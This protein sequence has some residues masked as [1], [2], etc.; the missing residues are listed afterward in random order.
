MSLEQKRRAEQLYNRLGLD[1]VVDKVLK[2]YPEALPG[3]DR[4]TDKM[5]AHTI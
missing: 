5:S 1:P 4:A 3:F 2:E